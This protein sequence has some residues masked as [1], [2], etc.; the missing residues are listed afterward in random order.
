[1]LSSEQLLFFA[2]NGYLQVSGFVHADVCA[3]LVACTTRLFPIGWRHNDPSTWTGK[4]KD[5]CH[6]AGL[7]HRG[8]ALKFQPDVLPDLP[9]I[10]AS[11]D[12]QAI[13]GVIARALIG[14]DLAP[15]KVRGLYP[16]FPLPADVPIRKF[17][18]GHIEAHPSQLISLCYLNDVDPGEGALLVWPGSHRDIYP[19][20]GSKLDHV[21]TPEYERLFWRW[22]EREPI[23]L[24]GRRGDI[25]IIH[26]RLL[27]APGINRGN[28]IRYA[29]LYDH[30]RIDFKILCKQ[31]PSDNLWE[32]WPAIAALSGQGQDARS[33]FDLAKQSSRL[34]M[35]NLGVGRLRTPSVRMEPSMKRKSDA[36]ALERMRQAGDCWLLLSDMP[37]PRE[38]KRLFPRGSNLAALGVKVRVNGRHIASLSEHDIIVPI[39][40]R[41]GKLVVDIGGVNSKLWLRLIETRLPFSDSMVMLERELEP[42]DENRLMITRENGSECA[43][44]LRATVP[45]KF[46]AWFSRFSALARL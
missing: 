17:K 26:H 27:H 25:I 10:R 12:S 4:A 30:R 44:E 43:C 45:S 21:A 9:A 39:Q 29:F 24:P 13:G 31:P 22:T 8:G 2:R 46:S 7:L 20:M 37:S 15:V 42:G 3:D 28:R 32:D 1:M 18:E 5:S 40:P 41:G 38:D 35:R 11:F 6:D 36:S 34:N 23:E 16:I 33:D 14:H 19:A